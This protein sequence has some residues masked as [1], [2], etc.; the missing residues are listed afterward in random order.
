M[1][2]QIQASEWI[3]ALVVVTKRNGGIRLCVDLRAVNQA[4]VADVFPLPHFEDL[5]SR[6]HGATLFSKLDARS[7]YHQVELAKASRDLTAFITPWGLFRY[8][9]VPFGLASAPAAFQRLMEK[10]LA[11]IEGVIIYL[12]DVLVMGKNEKEHDDRLSQVLDRIRKSGVT[13]NAK[14]EIRVPEIEFVGYSIGKDGIKPTEE[15]L[16]AIAC[17]PEPENATQV[18]SV[19][20][21]AS[22]YMRCVPDFSSIAEPMRRLLKA[23]AK[24]EWGAEQSEA[25]VNLK[26]AI[27]DTRPLAMFD[28]AKEIIVATDAPNVAQ[29]AKLPK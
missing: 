10:I 3:S 24:F 21:T 7:A 9:R 29:W 15:N 11:G 27:V 14:C 4:I 25:F 5:L 16:E 1:I 12:D 13:L 22:F 26:K 6:L 20:G 17:L 8:A 23:E 2:E 19:L 18:K 28:Y